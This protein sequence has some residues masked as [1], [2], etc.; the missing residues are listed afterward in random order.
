MTDER[1]ENEEDYASPKEMRSW[2]QAEIKDAARA[3]DL[4]VK[5]LVGLTL[6]YAAGELTPEKAEE[7]QAHYYHRWG[8]AL[9]GTHA[10]SLS[11]DEIVKRIDNARPPFLTP[12]VAREKYRQLF[13][14]QR[15]TDEPER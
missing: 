11:D 9:P 13:K 4:R 14:D 12:H 3:L 8:E 15:G 7:K 5:E 2:A 10:G 1:T 6:E